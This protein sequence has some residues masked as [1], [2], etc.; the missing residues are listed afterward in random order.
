MKPFL[1]L[2]LRPEDEAAQDELDAILKFGDLKPT[3]VVQ[4]RMEQNGIPSIV[5]ENYSAVIVGGGPS[6]VSDAM[7]KKSNEQ[8][9]FEKD[10]ANLLQEIVAKDFPYLGMCYGLGA[11]TVNQHGIMSKEKYG[12]GAGAVSI[13]LT[14]EAQTD[15]ILHGIQKTFRVFVGHKESCQQ[16]PPDAVWLA[17]SDACPYHIYRLGKNMY[18]TQFHPELDVEGICVRMDFYKNQGYFKPEEL[19]EIK[20]NC[21]KETITEPMKILK[22]FVDRYRTQ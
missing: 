9:R 8:Q 12:E 22:N 15:P 20:K 19:E 6:N 2:Q 10:L 5:L 11:L 17:S 13:T 1:I 14:N 3:E 7:E 21:R 4:I 18:A 16:L